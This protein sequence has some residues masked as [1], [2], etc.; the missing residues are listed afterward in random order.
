MSSRF[1]ILSMSYREIN[2]NE[3]KSQH[4]HFL[5][6]LSQTKIQLQFLPLGN[7]II[8]QGCWKK[9]YLNT[10]KSSYLKFKNFFKTASCI[11]SKVLN[12]C[13]ILHPRLAYLHQLLF[14]QAYADVLVAPHL[15]H[16]SHLNKNRLKPDIKGYNMNTKI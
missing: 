6:R 11:Y 8:F 2:Q 16:Q 9:K 14:L 13:I 15:P 5:T 4:F 3:A 1:S 7:V 10:L 12:H